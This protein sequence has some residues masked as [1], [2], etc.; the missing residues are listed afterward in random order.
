MKGG[1]DARYVPTGHLV[2][3]FG[4]VLY[5]VPFDL[6]RLEVVGGPVPMIQG[7]RRSATQANTATANYGLS[8]QGTLVYLQDSG[9]VAT[10]SV[11]AFVDRDGRVTALNVT[12]KPY[13]SPRVSPD[14]KLV[15]V[16]AIEPNGRTDVWI[17]ELS[18]NTAIRRLTTGGNNSRPIWTPDGK[19]VTFT[20]D[21]DGTASIYWQPADG[22]GL[23][24]R[25]T[26]AEAGTEHYAESWSPDGR[27]LSFA[28]VGGGMGWGLWTLSLEDRKTTLF[29]DM[30]GNQFGS[31]FSPDAKW[32]A[33]SDSSESFGVY[34]Q[35]FP[36]TGVKYQITG[37]GE[38]W[39]VWSP[40][41]DQL[42]FRRRLD[43][44]TSTQLMSVDISTA[45]GLTFRNERTV[46]VKS[47]LMF[48]L[49]RDY[50]IMPDGQRF[51]IIYP[52]GQTTSAQPP[53]PQIH[54]VLNWLEE[55]KQRVPRP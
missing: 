31:V 22:S 34:V 38:A 2:Y 14:G 48:A 18:G 41:G 16:Q 49:Y 53:R 35:P 40:K 25:L 5:A 6:A 15:A 39:P 27:V 9:A 20:S 50:D 45:G 3:A 52:A 19:R 17:Y 29:Y 30:D 21:R 4:N 11:L 51:V 23:A 44:Q 12:P 36:S 33:Y 24:E 10:N 8:S 28:S 47:A 43:I 42:Y 54:V 13:F 37:N 32:L 46:P 1:S 26:A 7:V 55:L